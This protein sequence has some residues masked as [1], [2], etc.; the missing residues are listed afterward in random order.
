[1]WS[2][3]KAKQLLN[4][5]SGVRSPG[6]K[7]VIMLSCIRNYESYV[8]LKRVYLNGLGMVRC[9]NQLRC[10]AWWTQ[11]YDG[12]WLW[13]SNPGPSDQ[14]VFNLPNW[15]KYHRIQSNQILQNA[16][17]WWLRQKPHRFD[18]GR[19]KFVV[20]VTLI[21][22]NCPLCVLVTREESSN[23]ILCFMYACMSFSLYGD[24][25]KAHVYRQTI[26]NWVCYKN[27][28]V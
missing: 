22:L 8:Q 11:S 16:V 14:E 19:F 12:F 18:S 2:S 13:G 1:M 10:D 20:N 27:K 28:N 6:P 26:K 7:P 21:F 25:N 23:L 15:P 4:S 9:V 24:E 3:G 17:A 5:M